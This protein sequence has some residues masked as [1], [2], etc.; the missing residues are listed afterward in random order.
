MTTLKKAGLKNTRSHKDGN[1]TI[2]QLKSA[3]KQKCDAEK[4]Y[5]HHMGIKTKAR[6]GT[7]GIWMVEMLGKRFTTQLQKNNH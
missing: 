4:R 1:R 5:T 6:K 2:E 7:D 3:E